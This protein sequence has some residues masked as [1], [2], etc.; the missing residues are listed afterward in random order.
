M[1]ENDKFCN[2][3][4]FWEGKPDNLYTDT[5]KVM[6]TEPTEGV[7]KKDNEERSNNDNCEDWEA[8]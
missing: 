8:K 6:D 7:C 2:N 3:C 1:N 5:D 4:R